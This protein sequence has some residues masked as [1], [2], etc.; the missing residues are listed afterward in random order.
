[1]H[2]TNL[3]KKALQ[4]MGEEIVKEL[5]VQNFFCKILSSTYEK[6]AT[7]MKSQQ[8]AHLNKTVTMTVDWHS[9]KIL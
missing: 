6:K 9:R 7:P 3:K 8:H 1:M 2:I 5:K 4:K